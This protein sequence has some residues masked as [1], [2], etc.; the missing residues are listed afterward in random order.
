MARLEWHM[1]EPAGSVSGWA[2]HLAA[3]HHDEG[4]AWAVAATDT[5]RDDDPDKPEDDSGGVGH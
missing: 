2:L 4:I 3:A 5:H 1:W